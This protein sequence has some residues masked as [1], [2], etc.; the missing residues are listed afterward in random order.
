[1]LIRLL[2]LDE[3]LESLVLELLAE[4]ADCWFCA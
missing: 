1:V 3:L 2:S 4:S